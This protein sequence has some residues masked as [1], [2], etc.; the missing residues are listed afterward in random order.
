MV[1]KILKI[2][3]IKIETR[4]RFPYNPSSSLTCFCGGKFSPSRGTSRLRASRMG[5]WTRGFST[6]LKMSTFDS[7]ASMCA[8]LDLAGFDVGS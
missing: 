1:T 2:N 3:E 5:S 7:K 8:T 6:S 4:G